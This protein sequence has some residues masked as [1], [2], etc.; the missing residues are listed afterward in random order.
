MDGL[1]ALHLSAAMGAPDDEGGSRLSMAA[2]SSRRP[3]TPRGATGTGQQSGQPWSVPADRRRQQRRGHS[4]DYLLDMR[5]IH[6]SSTGDGGQTAPRRRQHLLADIDTPGRRPVDVVGFHLEAAAA[7]SRRARWGGALSEYEKAAEANPKSVE[8]M[9]GRGRA[10]LELGRERE[11]LLAADRV[12]WFTGGKSARAFSLRAAAFLAAGEFNEAAA[13]A[14]AALP[15]LH[16]QA[17]VRPM[18]AAP[19]EAAPS[20]RHGREGMERG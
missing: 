19:A 16:Q 12:L 17:R 14:A 2:P 10:L 15:H 18:F 5:S 13:D 4:T 3:P 6:A 20:L 8:A 1:T 9:L 7:H 11:A